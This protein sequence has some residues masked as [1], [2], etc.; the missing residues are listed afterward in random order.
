AGGKVVI[1]LST[2]T[3][4]D[5]FHQWVPSDVKAEGAT[6]ISGR[7]SGDGKQY[8]VQFNRTDLQAFNGGN[9]DG[10]DVDVMITGRLQH[11]GISSGFATSATVRVHR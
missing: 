4:S 5:T 8:V 10:E 1:V 9:P 6:A 2:A 3:G 11:N 7:L